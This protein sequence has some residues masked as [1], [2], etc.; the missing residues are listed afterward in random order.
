MKRSNSEHI[1]SVIKAYLEEMNLDRKLKEVSLIKEWQDLVG[2]MVANRTDKL[3]ISN[4]IL[5]VHVR[6]SVVK[7]ELMMIREGL[8]NA[9]N[10]KA[11]E[12]LVREMVIR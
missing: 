7:N 10:E 4:G 2:V 12:T 8:I 1:G 9:L 6:S 5:Y 3:Y 11:G